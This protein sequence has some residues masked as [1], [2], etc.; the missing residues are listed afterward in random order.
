[1][2]KPAKLYELL[3]ISA[4]QFP[5]AIALC[6]QNEQITYKQLTLDVNLLEAQLSKIQLSKNDRVAIYSYKSINYVV[7][8]FAILKAGAAYI[9]IDAS[10]PIERNYLII[11]DCEAKAIVIEKIFKQV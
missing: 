4:I 9:P 3:E 10:A 8:Q 11:E 2:N 7:A 1:M 5:D 6:F